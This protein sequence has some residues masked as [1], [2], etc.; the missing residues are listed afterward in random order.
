VFAQGL[1]TVL[2][3]QVVKPVDVADPHPR[4]AMRELGQILQRLATD[5]EEVLALHVALGPLARRRGHAL[6]PML[7]QGRLGRRTEQ[8]RMGG[9]VTA[10]HDTHTLP[11]QV[12]GAWNP[13]RV[14]RHR[15]L[16]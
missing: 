10:G 12:E 16:V 15:V 14:R 5:L 11:V 13:H 6:G 2:L 4:S 9:L 8:A 7:G 3:Q 1:L